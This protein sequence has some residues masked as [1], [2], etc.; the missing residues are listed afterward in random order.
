MITIIGIMISSPASK[1]QK[2][3][4]DTP[5]K[6][7]DSSA[8]SLFS[9][10]SDVLGIMAENGWFIWFDGTDVVRILRSQIFVLYLMM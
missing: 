3:G 10:G 5:E 7:V 4:G 2:L 9:F 8:A 1:K 6:A